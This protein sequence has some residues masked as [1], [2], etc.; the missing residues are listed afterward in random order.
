M[1]IV[2]LIKQVPVTT[3]VKV[4][5]V[6]HNLV[7]EGAR[8]AVNPFDLNALEEALR[9][10]E[11]TGAEL[12]AVSMGPPQAV[13][14]LKYCLGLGFDQAILVSDRMFAGSDTWATALVL[15]T[16]LR[17]ISPDLILCGKMASD[18][19]TAQVP[20][21]MAEHLGIPCVTLVSRTL[22]IVDGEATVVRLLGDTETEVA[23]ALPAVLTMEKGANRPRYPTLQ[24][25]ADVARMNV[26][27]W[28]A[29][30]LAVSARQVGTAGSPTRVVEVMPA[31]TAVRGRILRGTLDEQLREVVETL[32]RR[33]AF[34]PG[35]EASGHE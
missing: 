28:T 26:Q 31:R 35:R 4:D 14:A 22:S 6:T 21:E 13:N 27:V 8:S 16:A 33:G 1:K 32:K 15:S 25:I 19:D 9:L 12:I 30:E 23:V 3:D 24:R 20:P 18:G 29:A 2:A 10:R 11:S 17:R 7:R 34:G 5:P